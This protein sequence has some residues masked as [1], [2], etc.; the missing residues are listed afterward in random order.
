MIREHADNIYVN[1]LFYLNFLYYLLMKI[2][3]IFYILKH[4]L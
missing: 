4:I 2:V 3:A 1:F